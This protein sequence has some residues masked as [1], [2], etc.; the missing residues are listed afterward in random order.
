MIGPAQ[1]FKRA[2]R[3]P[4][5]QV[6]APVEALAVAERM[7]DET[8]GGQIRAAQIALGEAGAADADLSRHAVRHRLQRA[9]G[10]DDGEIGQRLADRAAE[11]RAPRSL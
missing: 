1:V 8:D 10:E 6:A 9:V 4:A 3:E 11:G 7:R 2:V 5:R